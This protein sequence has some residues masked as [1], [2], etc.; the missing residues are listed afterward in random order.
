[1]AALCDDPETGDFIR[2]D[3][4]VE[5]WEGGAR[6]DRLFSFWRTTVPESGATKRVFVD[7]EVLLDLIESLSG[8]ESPKRKAFR[9]VVALVLLRKRLVRF[10][11]RDETDE[12]VRWHLKG[13][14]EDGP[15]WIVEDPGIAD[16]DIVDLHEQLGEV[17]QGDL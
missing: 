4:S 15:T 17:L 3:Y 1:V 12:G 16:D 11:R 14:G 2:K 13:R 5:A 8:E 7:D 9:F 6:P 10:E